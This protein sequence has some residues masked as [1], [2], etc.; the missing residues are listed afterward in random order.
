[1]MTPTVLVVVDP[2]AASRAAHAAAQLAALIAAAVAGR[3]VLVPLAAPMLPAPG[4]DPELPDYYQQ[5][6]TE[7]L[8]MAD[9]A[10]QL[11]GT[12][13]VAARV[14][15]LDHGLADLLHRWYPLL[16]VLGLA[17]EHHLLDQLLLHQALPV[18][19]DA[20]LPLLLVPDGSPVRLPE[21]VAVAAD[22][23]EFHL[24][25]AAQSL[26]PLLHSWHA[27]YCIVHV[28]ET[29]A[30]EATMTRATD[31]VYHGGLLP[32]LA[33]F[34]THRV[35]QQPRRAGL[36]QAAR[37]VQADL[38]VLPTRSRRLVESLF[39]SGVAAY[40]IRHS[41]VPVLL[42][43]TTAAPVRSASP[44]YPAGLASR[45]LGPSGA[46]KRR[47]LPPGV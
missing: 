38:L 43:P 46:G 14:E 12:V 15:D 5:Q 39:T 45:K 34:P 27:A 28:A 2:S 37:D 40:V 6:L 25:A 18:L 10:R 30:D 11:P 47:P 31:T 44:V 21:L 20:G 42:L 1:M 4:L 29:P 8:A 35:C 22:G 19:R 3:V 7:A 13:E 26:Q 9:L 24:A 17:P 33:H 16:L 32:G 41:P 23:E 36:V